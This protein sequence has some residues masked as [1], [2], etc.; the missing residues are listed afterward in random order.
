MAQSVRVSTFRSRA[1]ALS[2]AASVLWSGLGGWLLLRFL[3]T[4]S[5]ATAWLASFVLW[6]GQWLDFHTPAVP[7]PGV[8]SVLFALAVLAYYLLLLAPW[9]IPRLAG[10]R[11]R[12]I[13]GASLI[14]L[15][16]VVSVPLA[17]RLSLLFELARVVR[18]L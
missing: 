5:E 10:G 13:L 18:D 12:P 16:L 11:W 17:N 9:W 8:R 14:G 6:P 7:L 2:L 1:F 4:G 15:H 3:R